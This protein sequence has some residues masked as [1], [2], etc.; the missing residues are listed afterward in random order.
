MRES[1]YSNELKLSDF[2]NF[3]WLSYLPLGFKLERWKK[4]SKIWF[5]SFPSAHCSVKRNYIFGNFKNF[6]ISPHFGFTFVSVSTHLRSFRSRIGSEQQLK[7]WIHHKLKNLETNVFSFELNTIFRTITVRIAQEHLMK[8]LCLFGTV[9]QNSDFTGFSSTLFI[10]F[11]SQ[12]SESH[13]NDIKVDNSILNVRDSATVHHDLTWWKLSIAVRQRWSDLLASKRLDKNP[14]LDAHI[15][16]FLQDIQDHPMA[17]V[18]LILL[19]CHGK[20]ITMSQ[21]KT[22]SPWFQSFGGHKWSLFPFILMY[23]T[24]L[25]CIVLHV[26]LS[27][28]VKLKTIAKNGK[29]VTLIQLCKCKKYRRGVILAPKMGCLNQGHRSTSDYLKLL[30]L[31][32]M[33]Q[34]ADLVETW[35]WQIE[36]SL[37]REWVRPGSIAWVNV[38]QTNRGWKYSLIGIFPADM[39]HKVN[40]WQPP[41]ENF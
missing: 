20:F 10:G 19:N 12:E 5:I 9:C 27:T 23:L 14:S 37:C 41:A 30:I 4:F 35:E 6:V 15:T 40:R 25:Y 1:I 17:L 28:A 11:A 8:L 2:S 38:S 29:V 13:Q 34:N 31:E 36:R 3:V 26:F 33:E 32:G 7:P 22:K 39:R 21:N 24:A 16:L 18:E